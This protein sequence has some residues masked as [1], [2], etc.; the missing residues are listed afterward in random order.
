MH[1]TISLLNTLLPIMYAMA[2][3]AYMIDFFR[4]DQ[5]ARTATRPLLGIV[6]VLHAVYLALRTGLYEHIP[7]ASIFEVMTTVAFA[8]A[9]VYL[10]VELRTKT[11][12]TGMFLITFSF[13]FQ[14]VS[15]AFISN[16]GDFPQIL[17]SPLFGVHTGSAVLGYTSFAV[18]AIY[19]VL[20]LLLYHDLKSNRF[21]LVY[22]R[23][24]S[25]DLLATMSLRAAVLGLLFLTFTIGLG[26]L[27]GYLERAHFPHFYRDPKIIMTVIVW[28]VYAV[29]ALLHYGMGWTGKRTIY[30]SLFGFALII[31]SVMAVRL[32]LPSFHGGFEVQ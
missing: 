29:G 5:L 17:R 32:W 16:T 20:Y 24:P 7:L 1:A 31:L 10:Y 22:R 12:K 8:V 28:A 2:A 18:S 23:L 26:A 6:V 13:V 9:V 30:F 15:S 21:G 4:E 14:T 27:W 25:L 11:H 3:L 19:G